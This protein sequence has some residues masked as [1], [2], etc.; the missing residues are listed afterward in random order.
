MTLP[1]RRRRPL[2]TPSHDRRLQVRSF[3][4]LALV[5]SLLLAACGGATPA[6]VTPE[7]VPTPYPTPSVAVATTLVQVNAALRTQG[8]A[9]LPSNATVRVGEP[10]SFSGV[11]RWPFVVTLPRSA[12]GATFVIYEFADADVAGAAGADLAA[13]LATGPGRI[14][15][16]P[17]AGFALRLVGP[18][19]VFY[20]WSTQNSPDA[21]GSTSV[22]TAIETVGTEIPIT[23]T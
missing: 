12:A 13:Y 14:Q 6:P 10:P 7:P 21:T 4:L 11:A 1:N 9:A 8:L 15:Y 5:A 2:P 18:T 16:T 17:D 23:G 22:A 19:L 20:T 3:G